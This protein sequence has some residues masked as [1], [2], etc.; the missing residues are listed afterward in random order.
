MTSL[1]TVV[2]PPVSE[3]GWK[4]KALALLSVVPADMLSN[5][6]QFARRTLETLIRV[7]PDA[8]K[9]VYDDLLRLETECSDAF[10]ARHVAVYIQV[11]LHQTLMKPRKTVP[12]LAR[13]APVDGEEAVPNGGE[14][15]SPSPVPRASGWWSMW[16]VLTA[17]LLGV[18]CLFV[19]APRLWR[20]ANARRFMPSPG[21]SGGQALSSRACRAPTLK[22]VGAFGLPPLFSGAEDMSAALASKA[23]RVH[24]M[25]SALVADLFVEGRDGVREDGSVFFDTEILLSAWTLDFFFSGPMIS[26]QREQDQQE[27]VVEEVAPLAVQEEQFVDLVQ[28]TG[29]LS[30][31]SDSMGLLERL[32]TFVMGMLFGRILTRGYG[33]RVY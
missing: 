20:A 24:R 22:L 16:F 10:R 19:G 17:A 33:R 28:P 31:L 13:A 2:A 1:D 29:P 15:A 11:F 3:A 4:E 32:N 14:P 12:A 7:A 21:T 18:G 5:E 9:A 23:F 25:S 8:H 27:Q 30:V 6:E 26:D